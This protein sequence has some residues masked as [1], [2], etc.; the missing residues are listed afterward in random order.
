VI[1]VKRQ[2]AEIEPREVT[3]NEAKEMLQN[4]KEN[5]EDIIKNRKKYR[6]DEL[7]DLYQIKIDGEDERS[8]KR[9]TKTLQKLKKNKYKKWTLKYLMENVERGP[10]RALK[11]IHIKNYEGEI[12]KTI[13]QRQELEEKLIA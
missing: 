11:F 6:E 2:I 13:Y 1:E 5:W 12:V 7:L 4:T 3:I 9:R 10:K 8:T